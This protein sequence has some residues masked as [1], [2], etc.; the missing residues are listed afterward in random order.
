MKTIRITLD[1]DDDDYRAY[2]FEARSSG[3]TVEA[4]VAEVVRCL[5]R[6]L[7]QEERDGDHPIL[8]P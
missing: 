2:E 1:L 7:K 8:Y 5:Y 3:T 4:L 6:D